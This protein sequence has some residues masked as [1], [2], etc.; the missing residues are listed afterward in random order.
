MVRSSV[1]AQ[2]AQSHFA[3]NHCNK[4]ASATA[5][6]CGEATS[7]NSETHLN[8]YF[9]GLAD[10]VFLNETN[11]PPRTIEGNRRA[12]YSAKFHFQR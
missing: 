8:F 2:G 3:A 1:C 11:I 10:M 6:N 5:A 12:D 9:C 7:L 4:S